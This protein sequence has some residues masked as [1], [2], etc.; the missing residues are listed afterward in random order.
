M[1]HSPFKVHAHLKGRKHFLLLEK[2]RR[3]AE[4]SKLYINSVLYS[5]LFQML[6]LSWLKY[7][8]M[9]VWITHWLSIFMNQYKRNISPK[10]SGKFRV[11]Y[12]PPV[13]NVYRNQYICPAN[14]HISEHI[15]F[16]NA[17]SPRL[18]FKI[19]SYGQEFVV[20]RFNPNFS[21]ST[22]VICVFQVWH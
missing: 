17:R 13:H 20:V 10:R 21:R 12:W 14:R 9:L 3:E 2:V 18:S 6:Y 11:S 22:L 4:Y 7:E 5:D 8:V 19:W 1:Q 16:H 15:L